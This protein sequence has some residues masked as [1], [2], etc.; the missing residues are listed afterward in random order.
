MEILQWI[1][2][3]ESEV[4]VTFA[5]FHD[6]IDITLYTYKTNFCNRMTLDYYEFNEMN[7][8][9]IINILDLMYDELSKEK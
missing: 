6:Q 9:K 5:R 1:K 4:G 2:D 3:H 7:S 8:E